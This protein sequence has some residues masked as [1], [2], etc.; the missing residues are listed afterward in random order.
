MTDLAEGGQF[1]RVAA[2]T[3]A[4]ADDAIGAAKRAEPELRETTVV[5]RADWLEGIAE[6]IE[7]RSEELAEIVVREAGKPIS[8]A[9]GE[10][11]AAAE[12]FRRAVEEA[13]SL[14]GDY[15]EGTTEGHEGWRA[16]VR[17]EPVGTVL[18]VSPCNY[19][20]STTALAVAPTL[21]A[22]NAVVLKPASKTPVSGAVLAEV[23]VDAALAVPEG[24][25]VT[26]DGDRGVVYESDIVG[27]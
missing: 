4:D 1:A 7:A 6:G 24:A 21:A 16:I 26:V 11:E 12:R 13:R 23:I 14:S 27:R 10:A 18:C 5:R 25:V 19:P 17:K 8:S 3:P 22:G 9:R 2:A 15:V 20:L